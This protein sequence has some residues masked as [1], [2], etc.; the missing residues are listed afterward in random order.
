MDRSSIHEY[1]GFVCPQKIFIPI[2][3]QITILQYHIYHVLTMAQMNSIC[4]KGLHEQV[5]KSLSLAP[6]IYRRSYASRKVQPH[7]NIG[8]SL[9]TFF[10]EYILLSNTIVIYWEVHFFQC[11]QIL[12]LKKDGQHITLRRMPVPSVPPV[13]ILWAVSLGKAPASPRVECLIKNKVRW[14]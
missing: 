13:P 8:V 11:F 5:L 7:K 1:R 6:M 2:L 3:E 14:V 10:W 9:S 12:P 4:N